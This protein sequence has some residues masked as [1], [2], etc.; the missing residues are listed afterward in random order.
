MRKPALYFE[1][2]DSLRVKCCLCPARCLLTDGKHGICRSRFN[3]KGSLYT[4][5]YGELVS[6]ANDPVEK[7]PLY[8]FY[9]GS[10]ILSTGPNCCSLGCLHCQNWTISQEKARTVYVDPEQLSD[11]AARD[12]SIGVA[13]TYTEPLMWFEYILDVA[14]LLRQRDLKVVLVTNGY[15]EPEP[16]QELLPHVDAMNIDL[17][18]IR[19]RF[20]RRICKGKLAPVLDNI[21]RVAESHVLLEITNLIIPG[22][23]D[24]DADIT[25]LVEFVADLSDKIP[26]HFS[27]YR[28]DYKMEAPS[29]PTQ[30]LLR[31]KELAAGRLKYVYLGN[32]WSAE[33]SDTHCPECGALLVER[34]GFR[35]TV[36]G[37]DGSRCASCGCDTGIRNN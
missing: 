36:R 3:D 12:C 23:N 20:Y 11:Q 32:V 7:K 27:A 6:L 22:E 10:M 4:D 17:K 15:L 26:V 31:A 5:N 35:A 24:S 34:S 28:P 16:L 21:R 14:P 13:F 33:G 18:S 25:D 8:H 19:E 9:P 37:L 2:L 1:K 29:T 30:T